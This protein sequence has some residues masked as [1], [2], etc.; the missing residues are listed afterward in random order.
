MHWDAIMLSLST[1]GPVGPSG[2][3]WGGVGLGGPLGMHWDA[4]K[5]LLSHWGQ[6][7]AEWGWVIKNVRLLGAEW[8]CN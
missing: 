1:W 7:G 8:G 3:E 2:A 6:S 5:Q 4:I